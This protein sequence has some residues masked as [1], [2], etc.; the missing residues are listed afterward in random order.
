MR[1]LIK[2]EFKHCLDRAEWKLVFYLLLAANL[3][4]YL[5]CVENDRNSCYQFLRGA[6]ENTFLMGTT[7]SYLP[8]MLLIVFPILA[9]MVWALS[10]RREEKKHQT[11]VLVQRVGSRAYLTCKAIV[12]S[13]VTFL[14][15]CVPF[16]LN[17]LLCYLTYPLK[18]YDSAWAEPDYLIGAYSYTA[19]H[20]ADL[21][22]LEH[23]LFYNLLYIFNFGIFAVGIALLAYALSFRERMKSFY[24]VKIPVFLFAVYTVLHI[25]CALVGLDALTV[26]NYLQ[27]NS[28]GNFLLWLLLLAVLFGYDLYAI[29]KGIK[30]YE[31][32]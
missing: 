11:I 2:L 20:F 13:A 29:R 16:L 4:S 19:E 22:R 26:Q 10:L 21:L 30:N 8:Y 24:A 25:A 23:P 27:P 32:Y 5:I 14:A 3:A 6:G 1:T 31:M 7:A 18:G 15:V 9:V 17:L 28:S 12:I